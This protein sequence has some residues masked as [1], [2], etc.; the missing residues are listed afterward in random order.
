MDGLEE[1]KHGRE[2]FL[3]DGFVCVGPMATARLPNIL[4]VSLSDLKRLLLGLTR[5]LSYDLDL[6]V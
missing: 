5:A 6:L 1:L 4:W 2:V 3:V